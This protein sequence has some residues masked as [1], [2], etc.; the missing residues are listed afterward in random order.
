[1]APHGGWKSDDVGNQIVTG[2]SISWHRFKEVFEKWFGLTLA[3][4]L[5]WFYALEMMGSEDAIAFVC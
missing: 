4:K 5:E 2:H 1:M 3:Q